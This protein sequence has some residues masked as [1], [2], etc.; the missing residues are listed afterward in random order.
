MKPP[1]VTAV[2]VEAAADSLERPAQQEAVEPQHLAREIMAEQLHKWQFTERLEAAEQVQ[3]VLRHQAETEQMAETAPPI[4][5]RDHPL[6]MPEAAAVEPE[7]TTVALAVPAVLV[8]VAEA[9]VPL[10]MPLLERPTPEA[11]AA[12]M[13]FMMGKP[14]RLAALVLSLLKFHQA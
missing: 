12:V 14:V 7:H 1:E 2:L 13:G 11:V 6:L 3:P 9:A 4:Q 8:A 10:E 5:L